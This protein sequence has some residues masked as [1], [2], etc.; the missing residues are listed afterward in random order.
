MICLI[1]Q[2]EDTVFHICL[3]H[4]CL[5]GYVGEHFDAH[6]NHMK[7]RSGPY[8]VEIRDGSR[9]KIVRRV[10]TNSRERWR[11]QNVNGAFAELRGLI[12]T[13]PPDKKLSK[14]EI[15]RLTMKY[16]DFLANLLTDQEGSVLERVDGKVS[17]RHHLGEVKEEL[18]QGLLSPNSSCG[19]LLD[20]ETSAESFSEDLDSYLETRPTSRGLHPTLH[21]D[22]DSQR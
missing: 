3:F 11:Q 17:E 2:N 14:N 1:G 10:F 21:L 16:I 8:E 19:S 12:P 13:H 15:L 20:E 7:R 6:P 4:F 22:G 5:S 9:P 18:T